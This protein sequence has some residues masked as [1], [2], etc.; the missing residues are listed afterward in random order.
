MQTWAPQGVLKRFIGSKRCPTW[1]RGSNCAKPWP[2]NREQQPSED[3]FLES[4]QWQAIFFSDSGHEQRGRAPKL[5][6]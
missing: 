3:I 1:R 2:K 4:S 5:L 6:P